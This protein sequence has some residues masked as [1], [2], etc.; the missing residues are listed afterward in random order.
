MEQQ[1]IP[2]LMQRGAPK[3]NF[4]GVYKLL[5]TSYNPKL[6]LIGIRISDANLRAQILPSPVVPSLPPPP[7]LKYWLKLANLCL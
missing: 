5:Q 1:I 4:G 2:S 3:N 6:M 7:Q